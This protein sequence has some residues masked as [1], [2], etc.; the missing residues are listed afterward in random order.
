[1]ELVENATEH[2]QQTQE[3]LLGEIRRL[4]RGIAGR[5]VRRR[6]L[7]DDIAQDVV[8]DCLE[9]LRDGTWHV[10]ESTLEAY[11]VCLVKRR[12]ADMRLRR[13]RGATR[14]RKHLRELESATHAWMEP[15]VQM[16]EQELAALYKATLAALPLLTRRA[17]LMVREAGEPYATAAEM[18]GISSKAVA[19][20]VT[21]AQHVFRKV[22]SEHGY[23]VPQGKTSR[24][25]QSNVVR[26]ESRG[27][28]VNDGQPADAAVA[29]STLE[30]G[31]TPKERAMLDGL[32]GAAAYFRAELERREV[33]ER[34][35]AEQRR[36]AR[37]AAGVSGTAA[38]GTRQAQTPLAK[39]GRKGLNGHIL[40]ATNR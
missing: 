10:P 25:A 39:A 34:Q 31:P 16:E 21:R 3:E 22:L 40:R 30:P 7:A 15:D 8:L 29:E 9:S 37:E 12:R 38:P 5:I 6:D 32:R 17:F 11:V 13:R 27:V 24:P 14:D 1:M 20:H 4:A 28:S 18:L 19:A 2:K 35:V 33:E 23:A 36:K 26:T